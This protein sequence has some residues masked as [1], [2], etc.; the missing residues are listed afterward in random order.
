MT[1]KGVQMKSLFYKYFSLLIFIFCLVNCSPISLVNP[2]LQSIDPNLLHEENF[3][4]DNKN[5]KPITETKLVLAI[6]D[7]ILTDDTDL[8]SS[9]SDLYLVSSPENITESTNYLSIEEFMYDHSK[10]HFYIPWKANTSDPSIN[11]CLVSGHI[12]NNTLKIQS[13]KKCKSFT[14][15]DLSDLTNRGYD[16]TLE[17]RSDKT[18]EVKLIIYP[19]SS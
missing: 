5:P 9:F 2:H 4:N 17:N 13:S 6:T 15:S 14:T 18:P 3:N 10:N 16:F 8:G 7:L 11:I 12:M 19:K 1:G